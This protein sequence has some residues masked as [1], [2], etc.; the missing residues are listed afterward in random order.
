MGVIF[1][2]EVARARQATA[3][4]RCGRR[5][6]RLLLRRRGNVP[7]LPG[8]PRRSARLI[9]QEELT[10]RRATRRAMRLLERL[11]ALGLAGRPRARL[12]PAAASRLSRGA[13][14]AG[15]EAD[16][17]RRRH[18]RRYGH[19]RPAPLPRAVS[20][21]GRSRR[22]DAD[23][24]AA[25]CGR[26]DVFLRGRRAETASAP[27]APRT[28]SGTSASSA[29]SPARR[30]SCASEAELVVEFRDVSDAVMDRMERGAGARL[31]RERDGV[32]GVAVVAQ[33]IGVDRADRHG[34]AAGRN[35]STPRRRPRARAAC[36]CRAARAMMR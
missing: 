35:E 6:R 33:P 11:D 1:A 15:P 7:R 32:G 19:R 5:R 2:L 28:R 27:R 25:R 10:L 26:G 4:R 12:D 22:H 34:R 21:P 29:S 17:G 31:S 24:D 18:R 36:A 14:R 3:S 9:S 8:Q 23:G 16:R 13:Y 20:G 30:M